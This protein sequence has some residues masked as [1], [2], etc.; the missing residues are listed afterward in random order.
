MKNWLSL[1]IAPFRN[2][3]ASVGVSVEVGPSVSQKQ[4]ATPPRAAPRSDQ[5]GSTSLKPPA[6]PLDAGGTAVALFAWMVEREVDLKAPLGA[7]ERRA[8][9]ELDR[10]ATD[11]HAKG[12]LLPRASAV[13]PR[14]LAQ[15]RDPA[16]SLSEL[17][18][19]VSRDVTL[20]AEVIRMANSVSYRR[21]SD[22]VD[23]EQAIGV[24]GVDGL[25]FAI[26]RTVLKPLMDGRGGELS[27]RAGR[28]L[29]Q[30]TDCKAQLSAAL[31]R[32][33]GIDPFDAYLLALVHDAV[34]SAV[35]RTMDAVVSG[36]VPW[37]FSAEF[38]QSLGAPRD[39][40][41]GVVAQQWQL[42][43]EL[44]GV[45][46]EV[47]QH[48]LAAAGS[49]APV[50][51]LRIADHLANLLCTHRIAVAK[52]LAEPLL[53]KLPSNVRHSYLALAQATHDAAA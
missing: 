49:S 20:V 21:Q 53:D 13:V 27:T 6:A 37:Q 50:R 22:V 41:F 29:W 25:R 46:N 11:A 47:A 36:A 4:T 45:A 24:L 52:A 26:A 10:L 51:S 8:L 17:S 35:F 38:V 31:A 16:T 39:R 7:R 28:R 1:L 3:A 40:L 9:L 44:T 2:P 48:G 19:Q 30:H 15:L 43:D 42:S 12:S 34:W 32:G 14:L 18:E 33:E 5:L 23:L